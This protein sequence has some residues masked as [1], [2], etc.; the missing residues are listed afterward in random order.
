MDKAFELEISNSYLKKSVALCCV[1][2]GEQV[3]K[4]IMELLEQSIAERAQIAFMEMR[5]AHPQLDALVEELVALSQEVENHTGI[6][7]KDKE[8]VQRYLSRAAE[9]DS[10][11]QKHLYIQGAKDCVALLRELGV[12]K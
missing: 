5:E 4:E 9:V 12:I 7:A 2:G 3:D 10:E 6:A 11:F 1:K 8:L